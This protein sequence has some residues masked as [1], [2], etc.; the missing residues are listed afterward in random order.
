MSSTLARAQLTSDRRADGSLARRMLLFWCP[1]CDE[2]HG[3][4][5]DPPL[6]TDS[7]GA[8]PTW[9]WNGNVELPTLS[10]SLH[11]TVAGEAPRVCHSFIRD[12]RIEFLAD[13]TH[14]LAG[15]TVDLPPWSSSSQ[16]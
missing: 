14:G 8:M 7:P 15:H 6:A 12:G 5:I 3:I 11:L 9:G 4:A 10:P 13:C 1:G 16:I 2:Q